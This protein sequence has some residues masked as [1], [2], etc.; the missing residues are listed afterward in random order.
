MAA[1][2]L[3]RGKIKNLWKAIK[4]LFRTSGTAVDDVAKVGNE[5]KLLNSASAN[6]IIE[7]V[8]TRTSSEVISGAKPSGATTSKWPDDFRAGSIDPKR[9]VSIL[10]KK[11][12][13]TTVPTVEPVK[14]SSATNVSGTKIRTQE[15]I[16]IMSRAKAK[17]MAKAQRE[18]AAQKARE[19]RKLKNAQKVKEKEAAEKLEAMNRAEAK[20][21]VER[22][23]RKHQKKVEQG[24][25][26]AAKKRN[27]EL[28]KQADEQNKKELDALKKQMIE[29]SERQRLAQAKLA[30]I[31]KAEQEK[32]VNRALRKNQA[33]VDQRK[34]IEAKKRNAE[35]TKQADEQSKAEMTKLRSIIEQR[36]AKKVE[37][38]H[39]NN[40][41]RNP[42]AARDIKQ[43]LNEMADST[44]NPIK[45]NEFPRELLSGG[46]VG[47]PMG[48]L[49]ELRPDLAAELDKLKFPTTLNGVTLEAGKR[50]RISYVGY[51]HQMAKNN[52]GL[53]DLFQGI[54]PENGKVWS[55][56]V[57]LT[58]KDIDALMSATGTEKLKIALV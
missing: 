32:I 22:A 56:N 49:E 9:D 55:K 2:V 58:Q 24:D 28:T 48:T 33:K 1:A 23:K 10:Y 15:E 17:R 19:A 31:E 30:E 57:E 8:P 39:I 4:D 12:T 21:A 44:T 25:Y 38:P 16:D 50:Y 47:K 34:Y 18:M 20:K 26:I 13:S 42:E 14:P 29:S 37:N 53:A 36:Y 51:P 54:K 52:K 35:L 7:V 43:Q 46:N 6:D 5:T 27:A 41:N 3:F 40:V 45:N 11:Q